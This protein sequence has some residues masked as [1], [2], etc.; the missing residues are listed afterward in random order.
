MQKIR[1][2]MDIG[3][4]IQRLRRNANMTQ[5]QVVAHLQLIG[6]EISKS[7]YAKL[8]TNRMNIKVSELMALSKIFDADIAEFFSGLL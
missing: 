3:H 7:T 4:N 8:E 6:I 1:P 2:D 5:E